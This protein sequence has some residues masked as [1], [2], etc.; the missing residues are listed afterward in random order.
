MVEPPLLRG[1][2][3]PPLPTFFDKQD[4]LDLITLRRHI[5]RLAETGIAGYVVMGTNGEAVHLTQKERA[6]VIETARAA[7]GE[8]VP[9]LAGCGEQ[10]TRATIANCQQAASSGADAALV[11]PPFYFKGSMGSRALIAHY[12]TVADYSPL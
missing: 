12:H 2:I 7:A 9:I 3:Y 11:L 10:S 8:Q 1:G 4:D 5:Q 6:Q